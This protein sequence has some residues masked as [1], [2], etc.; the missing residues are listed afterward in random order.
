MKGRIN[1]R[2]CR[3][4]CTKNFL[5]FMQFAYCKKS[6]FMIL[7]IM[8]RDERQTKEKEIEMKRRT[9]K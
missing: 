5:K 8:S 9:N 2:L 7:Y 1:V 6:A 4:K 3:A